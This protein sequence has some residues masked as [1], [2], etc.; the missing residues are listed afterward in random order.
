MLTTGQLVTSDDTFTGT[1]D[2]DNVVRHLIAAGKTWKSYAESLPAVG[3]TDGDAY[4]YAKRRN[5]PSYFTDLV[6]SSTEVNLRPQISSPAFQ[7]DG[8][9]HHCF[10]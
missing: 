2:A 3:F 6:N 5:P 9:A 1:V 10:R 7:Q 4:P 8:L